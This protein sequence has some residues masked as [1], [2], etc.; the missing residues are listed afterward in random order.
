MSAS[1]NLST[2]R[3]YRASTLGQTLGQALLEL[4]RPSDDIP[5][6]SNREAQQVLEIFDAGVNA[7]VRAPLTESAL[8]SVNLTGELVHYSHLNG[9]WHL[10]IRNVTIESEGD[11]KLPHVTT[12]S[13]LAEDRHKKKKQKR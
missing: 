10:R 5:Q 2:N 12:L 3:K 4:T 6:I 9:L 8:K 1:G 11:R 13:V 7:L